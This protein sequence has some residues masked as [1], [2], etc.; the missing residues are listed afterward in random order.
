[1]SI[2]QLPRSGSSSCQRSLLHIKWVSLLFPGRFANV[3]LQ[4]V[5]IDQA[6]QLVNAAVAQVWALEFAVVASLFCSLVTVL[7]LFAE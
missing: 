2:V 5:K 6:N 1:M 7:I 3:C 4:R